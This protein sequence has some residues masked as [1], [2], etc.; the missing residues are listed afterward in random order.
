M[1]ST[2]YISKPYQL[3]VFTRFTPWS[4]SSQIF[5]ITIFWPSSLAPACTKALQ[6]CLKELQTCK[7]SYAISTH[8][9]TAHQPA[10]TV[11]LETQ[12]HCDGVVDFIHRN[13]ASFCHFTVLIGWVGDVQ[14]LWSLDPRQFGPKTLR[15]QCRTVRKTYRHWC[16]SVQTHWHRRVTNINRRQHYSYSGISIIK[17]F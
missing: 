13:E 17:M 5:L 6:P 10:C 9:N 16:C 3:P 12:H 11:Y 4:W 15:H 7:C 14:T 2:M 1:H 8:G